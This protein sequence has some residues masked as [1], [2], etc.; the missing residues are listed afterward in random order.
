MGMNKDKL[1]YRIFKEDAQDKGMDMKE[2][3]HKRRKG[4]LPFLNSK[5]EVVWLKRKEFRIAAVKKRI[6][7]KKLRTDNH[8][9]HTHHNEEDESNTF[10]E[11]DKYKYFIMGAGTTI[12]VYL[13]VKLLELLQIF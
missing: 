10:I 8:R 3:Y 1:L 13:F 4:F 11:S 6:H 2:F 12:L 5:G 9:I 7:I